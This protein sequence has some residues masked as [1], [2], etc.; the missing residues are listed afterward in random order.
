VC[1]VLHFCDFVGY[2]VSQA[3]QKL[4][5]LAEVLYFSHASAYLSDLYQLC[6]YFC[7]IFSYFCL[8]NG[9][10][11]VEFFRVWCDKVSRCAEFGATIPPETDCEFLICPLLFGN[12]HRY[13]KVPIDAFL[14]R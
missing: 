10:N 13:G 9:G 5:N 8:M 14:D 3:S 11:W 2:F 4:A 7:L 12:K 6:L 1:K